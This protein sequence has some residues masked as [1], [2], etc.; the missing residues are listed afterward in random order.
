M[1]KTNNFDSIIKKMKSSKTE[2]D[3]GVRAIVRSRRVSRQT[4]A[5]EIVQ[6][7]P[8]L[9]SPLG[10]IAKGLLSG[11]LKFE[12]IAYV[13][14][15]DLLTEFLELIKSLVEKMSY[16][17]ESLNYTEEP[18]PRRTEFT[19]FVVELLVKEPKA[20]ASK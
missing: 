12:V 17:V 13:R 16:T 20:K 4:D 19:Q 2:N 8:D 10:A 7:I 11:E 14:N 1:T 9:N 6:F 3:K 5:G 18:N 15:I